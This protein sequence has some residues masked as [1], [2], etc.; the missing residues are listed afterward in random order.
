MT[1]ADIALPLPLPDPLTYEVPDAWALMAREGVRARVLIGRR[2]L[3]GLIVRVHEDRPEG[4][5]LRPLEEILDREP[6]VPPDLLELAR[7]IADYYMAPIGE[8]VRSMLPSDLPPWGD[9][10]VRLT[11]AGAL[12]LP[13]SPSETA[14][15]AALREGGRMT[16]AELQSRVGALPDLDATLAVL[17]EGGRIGSAEH[18]ARSARY[19]NAVELA[20]GGLATHLALAGKSVA[21]REVKI[22]RAHV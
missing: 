14:V 13:R 8:V 6:V 22:G 3:T 9:R 16:V 21:G 17:A 4:V 12:A 19:I 7:F 18:R 15:I 1:L 20:P 11:D 5:S 10:K 2:R